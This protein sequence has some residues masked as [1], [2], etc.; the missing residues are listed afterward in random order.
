METPSDDLTW[1]DVEAV[2]KL[3][4]VEVVQDDWYPN[5]RYIYNGQSI[6]TVFEDPTA[7]LE[8]LTA[9]EH[10]LAKKHANILRTKL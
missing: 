1:E 2:C 8:Y 7:A 3:M 6:S 5:Q 10:P 4:G 9:D